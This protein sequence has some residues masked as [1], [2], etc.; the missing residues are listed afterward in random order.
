MKKFQIFTPEKYVNQMLDNIGY[1]GESI[2]NKVFLENSVGK[3][4]ILIEAIKRYIDESLKQGKSSKQIKTDLEIYFIAFETDFEILNSCIENLD[5]FVGKYKIKNVKWNITTQDYLYT[6][7]ELTADY[8]V[9]NPPYISYEELDKDKREF[10]KE[11]FLS[12]KRGKFDY[13]YAFMEKSIRDLSPRSGK[14]AYLIPSSIFKNVF[15]QNLREILLPVLTRII[16]YKHTNIFKEALT[17][18]AIIIIDKGIA[19]ENVEYIDADLRKKL[20]LNK[21]NLTEKWYFKEALNVEQNNLKFGDFFK[22]ANSVA[23]LSNKV[24]LVSE[25]YDLEDAVIRPAASPRTAARNIQERII[26]PYN[27]E[28]GKLLRYSESYFTKNFPNATDYLKNNKD[29]LL[30]RSFDGEWFEYGRSQSL[31][32]LNQEKLMISSVIT[33]RVNVYRLDVLTIPYSGFYIV[34]IADRDLG[35][36]QEILES[37][38]FFNY[39]ETRAINASGRS[40]RI[41][42]NDIK[43]YPI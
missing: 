38:K 12:C 31:K 18:S 3:G 4:N 30:K 8:I 27:Y 5:N 16:D 25:N 15:A 17:S 21:I 19:A 1:K 35:F 41:S 34:P 39:L 13:C 22:V 29:I 24:F 40:I 11:N 36:A 33:E 32:F 20:S 43:N 42:V 10:L 23:T 14:L 28:N 7:L 2:L 37:E 26:F 9:G 6:E